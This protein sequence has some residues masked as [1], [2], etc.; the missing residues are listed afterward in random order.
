KAY[1][2]FAFTPFPKDFQVRE[3]KFQLTIKEL[4]SGRILLAERFKFAKRVLKFKTRRI[5][6][7]DF[8]GKTIHLQFNLQTTPVLNSFP[9]AIIWDAPQI[10]SVAKPDT[11]NILLISIDAL[12]ADHLSC[13][14]YQRKTSPYIDKLAGQSYIFKHAFTTY[15]TTWPALTSM[16]TS[17]YPSVHGVIENGYKLPQEFITLPEILHKN[18]YETAALLGNMK[19]ASHRGYGFLYRSKADDD[20][21]LNT[22]WT[23]E[24]YKAKKFFMWIHFWG[25]HEP[26]RAPDKYL[27]KF[28]LSPEDAILGYR[29]KHFEL[30]KKYGSIS[31]VNLQKITALYDANIYYTDELVGRILRKLKKLHLDENTIIILT[32][33]HGQELYQHRNYLYHAGSIYDAVLQIPLIIFIP[34]SNIINKYNGIEAQ[35]LKGKMN[36]DTKKVFIDEF[37]SNIDI[38]PTLLNLL[39]IQ[40]PTVFKGLNLVPVLEGKS[41]ARD[42]IFS[43][44]QGN[45]FSLRNNKWHYIYNYSQKPITMLDYFVF[46]YSEE[47]YRHPAD[48]LELH[49]LVSEESETTKKYHEFLINW[50]KKNLRFD[51]PAQALDAETLEQLKALGYI[52]P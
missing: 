46:D 7:D 16:M 27:K 2:E 6:L 49:N 37:T 39:N 18:G 22:L 44:A 35:R 15:G 29:K 30:L 31:N 5:S 48:I 10:F 41:L 50:A 51:V 47:L 3:L 21:A 12:R 28:N 24:K 52:N 45:V 23:L 40:V 11:P 13:Y 26:Y 42:W 34:H 1:L 9:N 20:L 19:K 8:I 38:A 25:T 43:E 14:G 32:T 36:K 33:D 4:Q 17:L